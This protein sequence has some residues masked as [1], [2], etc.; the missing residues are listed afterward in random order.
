MGWDQ[1]SV[2]VSMPLPLPKRSIILSSLKISR[3]ATPQRTPEDWHWRNR[4]EHNKKEAEETEKR[5]LYQTWNTNPAL[6]KDRP[7]K[8]LKECASRVNRRPMG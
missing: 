4:P 5:S 2:K 3:H 6:A 8:D 7:L 1:E